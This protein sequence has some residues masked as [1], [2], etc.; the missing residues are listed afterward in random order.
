MLTQSEIARRLPVWHVLSDLF[1]DTQLQP[2]DYSRI[3][4]ALRDSK[5]ELTELKMIL[6]EEVAPVFY[7]NL[8]D[9]AGEWGG[10]SVEQVR[11]IMTASLPL[12]A[13]STRLSWVRRRM[14]R[15]YLDDHWLKLEPLLD[16]V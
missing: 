13:G 5:F 1:L 15:R 2:D 4:L 16:A 14:L 12:R 8:L 9:V 3:A 11:E 6:T 10:W 7:F